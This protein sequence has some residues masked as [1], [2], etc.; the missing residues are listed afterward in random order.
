[1]ECESFPIYRCIQMNKRNEYTHT[2]SHKHTYNK[3]PLPTIYFTNFAGF[4]SLLVDLYVL[5]SCVYA[6]YVVFLCT[7]SIYTWLFALNISR[8]AAGFFVAIILSHSLSN[9]F[10]HFFS[11]SL[12][13]FWLC[14]CFGYIMV[15]VNVSQTDFLK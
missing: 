8:T 5:T 13:S 4:S 9:E 11:R 3:N 6:F 10:L 2:N 15:C 14:I 12:S 1:M 7:L